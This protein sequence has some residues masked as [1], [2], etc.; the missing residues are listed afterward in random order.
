M[1]TFD[2]GFAV[3]L[4]DVRFI[5]EFGQFESGAGFFGGVP[6]YVVQEAG[7]GCYT[8][9]QILDGGGDGEGGSVVDA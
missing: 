4:M 7:A 1:G 6:S 9:E 3:M 5:G 8:V 2:R